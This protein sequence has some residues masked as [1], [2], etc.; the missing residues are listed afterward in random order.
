MSMSE[1]IEFIGRVADKVFEGKSLSEK[2]GKA[3]E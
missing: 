2:I 1:F 3:I